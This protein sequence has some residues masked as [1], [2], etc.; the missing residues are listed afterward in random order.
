MKNFNN[1]KTKIKVSLLVFVLLFLV[2]SALQPTGILATLRDNIWTVNLLSRVLTAPGQITQISIPQT[3]PHSAVIL[4]RQAIKEEQ[5]DFAEQS[6]LPLLS[7]QDRAVQDTHAEVLYSL[8]R[9]IEAFSI[10]ERFNETIVLERA[11]NQAS[12]EGDDQSVLEAYRS[13]YRLDPE[14]YTSSLAFTLKA[15]GKNAEAEEL[16]L[17]S[18]SDYPNSEYGSDWLRY[19]ADSYVARGDWQQAENVYLQTIGE[20]PTD[21]RAW[22]NLGLLYSNQMNMPEKA[23]ECFQEMVSRFPGETYGYSLLAQSYEKIGDIENALAT[24]QSL[25][26]ISP[27]DT[28]A[29]QAVERLSSEENSN[30]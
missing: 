4:A 30:P 11:A 25:L 16:L 17:L 21:G 14:K 22:R 28:T 2:W 8:G 1:L 26:L 12:G 23:I 3:N 7:Y 10:W 15:H 18:R 19:L 27:D 5:L 20:N 13:L 9:K 29:L 24:Y 6:I